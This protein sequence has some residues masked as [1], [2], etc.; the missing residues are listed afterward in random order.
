MLPV[1]LNGLSR[2]GDSGSGSSLERELVEVTLELNVGE[3][4]IVLC[5][6][7]PRQLILS[8]MYREG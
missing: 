1:F 2:D 6:M 8:L 7:S 5:G 4:S 3:D